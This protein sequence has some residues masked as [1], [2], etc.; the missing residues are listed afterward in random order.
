MFTRANFITA[1]RALCAPLLAA[2]LLHEAPLAAAVLFALACATDF[3]DGAVARRYGE[4][5]NAGR[6]FDHS[7]DAFF[8]AAGLGALAFRGEIFWGL[9]PL[10]LL[11]FLQYALDSRAAQG[12]ALR[13]NSLGRWNGILY[14]VL[15]G[16][17]VARDA[18]ALAAPPA[19]FVYAASWALCGSTVFSMLQR[20]R[21]RGN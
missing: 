15:L 12:E 2:A 9:P 11:A 14:F 20:L 10:L 21:M 17:P 16:V 13:G 7:C 3:L 8:C 19:T 1:L 4:A 18:L 6:F 5:T